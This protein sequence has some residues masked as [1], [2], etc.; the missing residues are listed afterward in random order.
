[1]EA[2]ETPETL[3]E[4]SSAME[5]VTTVHD[6]EQKALITETTTPALDAKE[7]EEDP[8]DDS[9]GVPTDAQLHAMVHNSFSDQISMAFEEIETLKTRCA[10]LEEANQRIL[11]VLLGIAT[12]PEHSSLSRPFAARCENILLGRH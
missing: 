9:A 7:S 6:G 11:T 8:I 12:M 4:T 2:D 3:P 10:A 5:T 1:M